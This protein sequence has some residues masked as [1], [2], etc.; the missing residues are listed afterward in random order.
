VGLTAG[1][2]SVW[3]AE[4]GPLPLVDDTI[5]GLLDDAAR[6]APLREAVVVSGFA[7]LGF[8]VRWTYAELRGAADRL[9]RALICAGLAPGD[10]VAIWAPNVA[11][12]LVVEFA[13]AKADL[14]LVTINPTYRA[15]EAEYVLADTQARALFYLPRF[16]HFDLAAELAQIHGR[17]GALKHV[18]ALGP[19]SAAQVGESYAAFLERAEQAD[20]G[21][22]VARQAAVRPQDV[23]QIQYT[24]GTTGWSKGAMLTHQGLVNNARQF[25]ARWEV[26]SAERWANPMPLFHTAGCAMVTLACVAN[27]ATHCLAVWFDPAR[28]LDLVETERCTILET[29]PTMVS[30]LLDAQRERRRDLASLRLVGTGGA[31]VPAALGWRVAAEF[32]TRLRSVYGLTETSPLVA[33]APAGARGERGWDSAGP[34]LP[35]TSVR[36]VGADAKPVPVGQPG[37]VQVRGYLVMTGYL[38]RPE[39]TRDVIGTDG[40]FSTGDIG[41]FDAEGWLRIVGRSK[42]VI[43]RGGEN[44][45]PAE[46]ESIIVEHPAVAEACVVG[47]PDDYYGEEACAVVRRQPGSALDPDQLRRFIRDRV[48]HQKVPRHVLFVES[49]P[50]TASGKIRK[51]EVARYACDRVQALPTP[52][53]GSLE[54]TAGNA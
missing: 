47:V 39:A 20:T 50:T 12:W 40:W 46:I 30:A 42:D 5:G 45:Y 54:G 26:S 43:I 19:R 2:L 1:G 34:P 6:E 10:R 17:L 35:Y 25:A 18:V 52:S 28:V 24:S 14:V 3:E 51:A 8:D 16:R 7:D 29:V 13:V 31:P 41:H 49:F 48:T 32:G 22:L 4:P 27:R 21:V 38:N 15:G 53:A 44:L 37:Q 36:I 11:E 9:A 23:A 33:A